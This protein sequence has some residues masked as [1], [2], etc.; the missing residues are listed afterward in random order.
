MAE[1]EVSDETCSIYLARG[2]DNGQECSSMMKCRNCEP[3]EACYVPDRYL[4]YSVDEF[5]N[6]SGEEAM[7]QEIY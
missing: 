1:N 2:Y 6:F 5:G 4:T 3:G 7:K